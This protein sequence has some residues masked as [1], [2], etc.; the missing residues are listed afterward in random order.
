MAMKRFSQI[1][2]T[3]LGS[4]WRR[5]R[6]EFT[7]PRMMDSHRKMLL[8]LPRAHDAFRLAHRWRERILFAA[9][10]KAI[11]VLSIGAPLEHVQEWSPHH[12]FFTDSDISSLG[13]A[14]RR[15]VNSVEKERFQLAIDLS[16]DFDFATAQVPL[17]AKIP[18]RLGI[19]DMQN[20]TLAEKY[21]NILLCRNPQLDYES[22]AKLMESN[23]A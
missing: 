3:L 23:R 15:V 16:P 5:K 7:F 17:R 8:I 22:M 6:M 4:L 9:G 14:S 21:F 2:Q 19:A 20:V 12:L 10:N 13:L 1:L 11:V 18:I